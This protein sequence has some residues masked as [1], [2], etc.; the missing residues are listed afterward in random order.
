MIIHKITSI[1]VA[2]VYGLPLL[3]VGIENIKDKSHP[4]TVSICELILGTL[5]VSYPF[6]IW[7]LCER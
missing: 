4:K 1:L 7:W 3:I 5:F 6:I 2:I